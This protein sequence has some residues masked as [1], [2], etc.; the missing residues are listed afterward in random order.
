VAVG[1]RLGKSSSGRR[2]RPADRA[3]RGGRERHA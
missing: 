2:R 1:R 3:L